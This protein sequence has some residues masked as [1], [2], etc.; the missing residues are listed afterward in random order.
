MAAT[1]TS[2]E[3]SMTTRLISKLSLSNQEESVDLGN[4][5]CPEKGFVAPRLCPL[6]PSGVQSALCGVSHRRW[7]HVQARGDPYLF[8]FSDKGV[9]IP[10]K[11]GGPWGYKRAML[12]INDYDGFSNIRYVSLDFVWIWVEIQELPAALKT[13]A[14]A[15]LIGKTIESVLQ[16]RVSLT[17]SLNDSVRLDRRI[18]VLMWLCL[19]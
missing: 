11:R 10:V 5:R 7:M 9:M 17:L 4:L 12:L 13:V 14:T 6:N 18:K 15:G 2:S 3:A 19:L 1:M 8:T 16:V